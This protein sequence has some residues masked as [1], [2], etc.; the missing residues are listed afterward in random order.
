MGVFQNNLMGAAAAASA[1]GGTTIYDYQ[2]ANSV[3]MNGSNQYLNRT[4][5]STATNNDKKAI[6]L[7]FKRA[8]T[9]GNTGATYIISCQQDDLA[10]LFVND[11]STAD[12]VGYFTNNGGQNGKSKFLKRDFSAWNHL[13]FL[14]DSTE[15]TGTDRVKFYI[16]G[17]HYTTADSTFWNIDN[18]GYPDS[19]ADIGFGKGSNDNNIGRYQYNG[20]GYFN[21]YLADFVMIDGGTVPSISDFGETVNGV[22]VPK[23]PSGLTFGTNGCWLKF[24]SSSDLGNDSSGNNNDWTANNFAAHDQM[25]DS[26][27][28]SST[29]SNGGNFATLNPVASNPDVILSEGNLF[30]T[31]ETGSHYENASA[32]M[33]LKGK[34][35]VEVCAKELMTDAG[36]AV[37][38]VN[39]KED[40][41]PNG[42]G[43]LNATGVSYLRDGTL[44]TAGSA[45]SFGTAWTAGD[46]VQMAVD[47]TDID[48]VKVWFG[49]NNTWQNSGNPSAGSGIAA[50]ITNGEQIMAI[51]AGYTGTGELICNFGQEGTFAG[52][53]TAGGN[54]DANGYG[55]F[56]YAPP[57]N[58]L[59]LCAG[60]LTTAAEIDPAQTS[61]YYPQKLFDAKLYTGDGAST[62][63][64]SGMDFQPDFT[65]IKNRET[66]DSHCLF[67]STRGV[68]KLLSSDTTAAEATDADT[69][70]SWTSD[71]FTVGADVKVNTSGEDYVGW[72]WRANGGTT[73][74]NT[75]GDINSTVQVDPSGCF[76]IVTYTGTT[77]SAGVE[78][79]GHGLD[80]APNLIITKGV[81]LVANW[82]VFSDGQTSWNYGMNLNSTAASIDKSGNGSMSAPTSTVFS[83]NHTD[84]LN[85]T[86]GDIA[87]CFANCEGYIKS[88]TY[89]G[90]GDDNGTFVYTGFRPAMMIIKELVVDNWLIYDDE[91]LGYNADANGIGNAVL[92]PDYAYGESS[93]ASRAID[94]LS[95]GF[96]LRTSNATGNASSGNYLYF[97]MAKNPFQYATA[98]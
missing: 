5:S 36:Q 93:E 43:R 3:R 54:A 60:N 9:S 62:L 70:K 14:Y 88:G 96:K 13:V 66:T 74:T 12:N 37:G 38:L 29:D 64:I 27:T 26:P 46:I 58:F 55:N 16:N 47:M 65:W 89:V 17:V 19:S 56:I 85:D 6:S 82:W 90:N 71:G 61:D 8:G 34:Y 22:W 51:S 73:S 45:A 2:I 68:T 49:L 78:T 28:F 76:S 52:Q 15:S 86:E 33:N 84:G 81:G 59:A 69:L 21:G 24:E 39:V 87:Y 98:R 83:T 32:T 35:Y 4:A 40:L 20:S 48:S 57:T 77:S 25:L 41:I 23:D 67:D 50:T 94:I 42:T 92:Y 7:W 97:A 95:N 75:A 53:K 79:V 18:N 11:G 80:S 63:T 91:R 72:N 30:A 31:K 44:E 1:A 10:A